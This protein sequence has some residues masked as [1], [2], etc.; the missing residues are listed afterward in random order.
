M[1]KQQVLLTTE[2]SLQPQSY[3]LNKFFGIK[4]CSGWYGVLCSQG[5]VILSLPTVVYSVDALDL[6]PIHISIL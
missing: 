1:E 4:K 2:P 3:C 6:S 5:L